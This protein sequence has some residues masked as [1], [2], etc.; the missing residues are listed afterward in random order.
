MYVTP[1]RFIW[2]YHMEA[3]L[4][5]EFHSPANL[6]ASA[7]CVTCLKV[8]VSHG[9]GLDELQGMILVS[10]HGEFAPTEFAPTIKF[11]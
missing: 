8:P 4:Q 5:S 2:F 9:N 1:I 10:P 3:S 6:L 7:I 11:L